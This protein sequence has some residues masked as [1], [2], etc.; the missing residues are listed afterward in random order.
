[1][2]ISASD[3]KKLRDMTGAGMMDAKKAL[4]ENDGDFDKADMIIVRDLLVHLD[5]SDI[6]KCLANI[7]RN[8]FEYIA[9]TNYP[10]LKSQHKDKLLG[11]KWRPI[12][13]S[14]EPFSL[15]DPDYNLDDTSMIQDHDKEKYLSVWSNKKF[16]RKNS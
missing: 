3:V 15:I 6:L 10:T 12:N 13:L 8:D 11:D 2:S 16:I 5:T 7:K 9:I 1:M 4:S 14:M